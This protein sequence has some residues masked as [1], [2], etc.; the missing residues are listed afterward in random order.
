MK[1]VFKYTLT[2]DDYPTV[3]MPQGAEILHF[4]DQNGEACI[5]CLVEPDNTKITYR[6][7]LAGTGH[8]IDIDVEDRLHHIGTAKFRGDMMVF[9]LFEVNTWQ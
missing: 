6:F 1:K 3:V 4:D 8:P 2:W 7:R 5:W 9:H